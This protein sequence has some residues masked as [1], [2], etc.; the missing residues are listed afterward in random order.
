MI[1]CSSIVHLTS[2]VLPLVNNLY[3][4]FLW[5][6]VGGMAHGLSSPHPL[7]ICHSEFVSPPVQKL[8]P[9]SFFLLFHSFVRDKLIDLNEGVDVYN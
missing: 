8:L 6:I 2:R 7:L 4:L 9:F 3:S 1:T 5:V